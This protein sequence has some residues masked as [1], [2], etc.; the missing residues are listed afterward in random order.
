MAGYPKSE[1][2]RRYSQETLQSFVSAIFEGSG[3]QPPNAQLLAETLVQADLRGCH[4]HGVLRVPEY[5]ARL[6]AGRIDPKGT[7]KVVR[8]KGASIV[9]DGA[10]GMG[11][12]ASTFAMRRANDRARDLGVAVAAVGGSNHCGA[13]AYFAMMALPHDMIGL[14]TTNALPTMAPWGGI[15]K[16][17]G[18]NPLAV[19]LP[20]GDEP[21][22]VIDA[23][24]S[25]SSHGKIR[26]FHQ[27]GLALPPGWAFDAAGR[28]TTDAAAAINGLLQPIGEYKG[29]GFAVVMGLLSTALSAASYGTDLGNMVDGPT[30]GRDGHFFLA[31]DVR[32]FTEVSD[33]K[34]RV[35][36]VVRQ[37]RTS[38]RAEGAERIYSPGELEFLTERAYRAEG[39][40]LNEATVQDLHGCAQTLG[41]DPSILK[42]IEAV[43]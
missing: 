27:K 38:R 41:V 15:D 30:P 10:N 35:D 25:G 43:L 39:I 13:M 33:F 9:V 11:Q 2:E 28:P 1:T 19:A 21:P 24:F 36:A 37:M 8:E 31:L 42:Q 18:I 14:A 7:P 22:I 5:A 32:A 3:M 40:P 29:V 20:A 26:V 16:I 6:T 12:I 34:S 23:A 17:V 4:S